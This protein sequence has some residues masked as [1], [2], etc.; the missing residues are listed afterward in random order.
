MAPTIRIDDE[1]YAWLQEHARP[2]E[3]TPNSVLRRVAC[4]DDPPCSTSTPTVKEEKTMQSSTQ[5]VGYAKRV[6]L[7]GK[8]LNKKWK[9]GAK[10]ALYHRDGCWYNNLEDFPGA[11]FDPKGYVL[12]ETEQEYRSSRHLRITQETNVPDGI[13]SMP[14]YIRMAEPD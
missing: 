4:L 5:Q 8:L 1:V 10:H 11:L 3:D 6:R 9:V 7:S 2:F 14:G 12:F 13:S